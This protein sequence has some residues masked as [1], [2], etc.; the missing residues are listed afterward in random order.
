MTGVMIVFEL[1]KVLPVYRIT[2]IPG[3]FE[4]YRMCMSW[5]QLGVLLREVC[6]CADKN[7]MCGNC[8]LQGF[9][10]VLTF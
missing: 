8:A 3:G 4:S 1:V 7:E 10:R 9:G 2:F 6:T 5:T